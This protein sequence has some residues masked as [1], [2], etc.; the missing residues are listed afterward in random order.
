METTLFDQ[1]SEMEQML[2][3]TLRFSCNEAFFA[4]ID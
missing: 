1:T 3:K 2:P 4:E